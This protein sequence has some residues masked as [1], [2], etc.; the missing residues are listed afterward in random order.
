MNWIEIKDVSPN[1]PRKVLLGVFDPTTQYAIGE[2][3]GS[4]NAPE[5]AIEGEGG[6]IFSR[7]ATHWCE[8]VAP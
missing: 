5:I 3:G 8:L 7:K 4:K 6:T 2:L 1:S